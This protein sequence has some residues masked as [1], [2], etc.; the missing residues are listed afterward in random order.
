[1]LCSVYEGE[2]SFLNFLKQKWK[3]NTT[4]GSSECIEF[5][6]TLK[7]IMLQNENFLFKYK[8]LLHQGQKGEFVRIIYAFSCSANKTLSIY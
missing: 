8:H 3:K 4:P 6:I 7:A 5:T 1:M 2:K